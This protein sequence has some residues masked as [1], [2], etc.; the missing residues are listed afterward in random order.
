MGLKEF[1]VALPR[2]SL[3]YW[4]L[5]SFRT[6][7]SKKYFVFFYQA[8]LAA[9]RRLDGQRDVRSGR[10][11]RVRRSHRDVGPRSR[12][13]VF[14]WRGGGLF[15]FTEFGLVPADP[16][17]RCGNRWPMFFP[18]ALSTT[19]GLISCGASFTELFTEFCF[20]VFGF[21]TSQPKR[22]G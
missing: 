7:M 2:L 13:R 10:R 9:G 1:Y 8:L 19:I 15:L 6:L 3:F 14:F 4:V 21:W 11:R 12:Y 17:F 20:L 18:W 22:G 5:T 16:Q